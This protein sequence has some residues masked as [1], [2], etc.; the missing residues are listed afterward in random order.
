MGLLP[1]SNHLALIRDCYPPAPS[2]SSSSSNAI[3]APVSNPLGKLIFYAVH[4]PQKTP[5]VVAALAARAEAAHKARS[6]SSGGGGAKQ[7]QELAV[8]VDI[9]A[10]LVRE[11]GA[12][13]RQEAPGVVKGVVAEAALRCVEWALG[14]GDGVSGRTKKGR[15][16]E[17]EAKGASLFHAVAT[18]LS[19]PF[20]PIQ[21]EGS[22]GL[23]RQYLRCLSLIGALAQLQ[24]EGEAGSRHSALK[25]LAGAAKSDF[26][27]SASSA[28]DYAEQVDEILPALLS[29][30][31]EADVEELQ[32]QTTK[33]LDDPSSL[34]PL[35]TS[36]SS[37]KSASISPPSDPPSASTLSS[38]ALPALLTLFNSPPSPSALTTLLHAL[39]AFLDRHASGE[40]WR[41]PSQPFLLFLVRDVVL[42]STAS[43]QNPGSP[44]TVTSFWVDRVAEIYDTGTTHRSV[45]LLFVLKHLLADPAPSSAPVPINASAALSA[46]SEL[47]I[48]R[49]RFRSSSSA[50]PGPSP[51]DSPSHSRSNLAV[52]PSLPG[53]T[54]LPTPSARPSVDAGAALHQS[55]A[56][57]ADEDPL[58]SPLYAT[59]RAL[60]RRADNPASPGGYPAQVDELARETVGL[61]RAVCGADGASG[62]GASAERAKRLLSGMDGEERARAR[63]RAVRALRV[64][65]EG[66]REAE[67]EQGE[68]QGEDVE[69]LLEAEEAAAP[70]PTTTTA[71][72]A[73]GS[74]LDAATGLNE[75]TSVPGLH[76]GAVI[77][78]G[79]NG[80]TDDPHATIRAPKS[81]DGSS[82]SL[83][84]P[85][86]AEVLLTPASPQLSPAPSPRPLS[87][88]PAGVSARDPIAPSTFAKTLFLLTSSD[89][90]LRLEAGQA[91][92]AYLTLEA[93]RLSLAASPDLA[94]FNRQVALALSALAAGDLSRPPAAEN[95]A[96]RRE[97]ARAR[98]LSQASS[99]FALSAAGA[100]LDGVRRGSATTSGGVSELGPGGR[101][102]DGE[103]QDDGDADEAEQP[104]KPCPADY[105]LVV[106]LLPAV[107]GSS[108]SSSA[109]A[110]LEALPAF[111]HLATHAAERWAV[112]L[113]GSTALG[114]AEG[115]GGA[116]PTRARA[117][118]EVAA[119]AVEAVSRAGWG[120]K[121]LERVAG[122]AVQAL[123]PSV[124]SPLT[125]DSSS[126]DFLPLPLSN[127]SSSS[128]N[129][130]LVVDVLA[131]DARLQQ[132]SGLD[133]AGLAGVLRREWDAKRV[134]EEIEAPTT[135]SP[136]LSHALPSRS[137]V[138][139]SLGSPSRGGSTLRLSSAP[140]G[141]PTFTQSISSRPTTANGHTYALGNGHGS[142]APSSRHAS[143]SVGA[144]SLRAPSLADLQ[145]SLSGAGGG[146]G[147]GS[148]GRSVRTSAAPSVVS[149]ANGSDAGLSPARRRRTERVKTGEL[150]DRVAGRARAKSA[151]VS[152][153]G[154]GSGNGSGSGM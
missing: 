106:E 67:V 149:T 9:F 71:T 124:I 65:I 91:L 33:T 115:E 100:R 143:L 150:L 92:G 151:V 104:S 129:V 85:P 111:L 13:D 132:A 118:R 130:S 32:K 60:A 53:S 64:L 108:S 90:A 99:S 136:Y 94:R 39:L 30:V 34:K 154:S 66:A 50:R 37:R 78:N 5:K 95:A 48:R 101:E 2:S 146:A 126:T 145:F 119:R 105:A 102:V 97:R 112:G 98:T 35:P 69:Q 87:P 27:T 59:L 31:C 16:A 139:L 82:R 120:G 128:L 123:S 61:V 26:L 147:S 141:S 25:A 125:R 74:K 110:V 18:F 49:A 29:N 117:C 11:W 116:D 40:L 138:N 54:A 36:L 81:S 142:L 84:I 114:A 73:N 58:L 127:L 10:E 52:S 113:A 144:A 88:S 93:P 68:G 43:T 77:S 75:S 23:G 63:R 45:T 70:P 103:A 1:L 6:G 131:S 19:P 20:F 72:A 122:E 22:D 133:R 153:S 86:P 41:A 135:H 3:P 137:F 44:A 47:L 38:L 80:P 8:T 28:Q 76:L 55:G 17:M 109:V 96:R 4:R 107:F 152:R 83:S 140:P 42:A 12:S 14:G 57:A 134:K 121:E 15:D 46:L 62:A 7:R 148:G 89:P 24:G 79:L 21:Q 56:L 51:S